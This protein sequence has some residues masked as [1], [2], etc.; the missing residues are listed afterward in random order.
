MSVLRALRLSV[1]SSLSLLVRSR[2]AR[3]AGTTT[4]PADNRD[5]QRGRRLGKKRRFRDDTVTEKARDRKNADQPPYRDGNG[6]RVEVWVVLCARSI[7]EVLGFSLVRNMFPREG[8][9]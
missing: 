7:G 4:R 3:P 2:E 8:F 1:S 6:I 9:Y 5:Q